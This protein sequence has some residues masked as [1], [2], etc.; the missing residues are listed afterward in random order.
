MYK[1]GKFGMADPLAIFRSGRL[2]RMA[3]LIR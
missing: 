2:G 3:Y 1:R